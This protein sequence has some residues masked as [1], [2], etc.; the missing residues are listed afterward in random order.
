MITSVVQRWRDRRDSY[1]PAGETINPAHYEVAPVG[2]EAAKAFVVAHHYSGSFPV[3]WRCDGLIRC[4]QLVGVA[5]YSEPMQVAVLDRLPCPREAATEL[6]R[7]V[8]LQEEKAN[9][10]SYFLARSF[11]LRRR[12]GLEGI[13]SFADPLPRAN[14]AGGAVFGGHIGTIYQAT[15]AVY[16]GRNRVHTIRLLPDGRVI[17]DRALAKIRKFERNWESAAVL[18]EQFGAAPLTT[19]DD[20]RAWLRTWLPRLTRTARHPGKH[21]YLFGLDRAVKRA[22]PKS[23]PY[24]KL[25]SAPPPTLARAA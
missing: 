24:P 22:L 13:V 11:E 4:G 15:N 16:V 19:R 21:V 23:Q 14:A 25:I 5:V 9:A 7:F 3:A 12:D 1:R 20:P 2:R 8:L 18:L 17:S 6:G 10:E